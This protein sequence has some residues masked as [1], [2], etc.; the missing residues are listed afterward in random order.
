M[1]NFDG[2]DASP[3]KNNVFNRPLT[4]SGGFQRGSENNISNVPNFQPPKFPSE[5]LLLAETRHNNS[6]YEE[7][8]TDFGVLASFSDHP[9]APNFPAYEFSSASQDPIYNTSGFSSPEQPADPT[10]NPIIDSVIANIISPIHENY[11]SHEFRLFQKQTIQ[12]KQK[13][14]TS[15]LND[16]SMFHSSPPRSPI[17]SPPITPP[18]TPPQSPSKPST[19][20]RR[21]TP[22][23]LAPLFHISKQQTSSSN[24]SMPTASSSIPT[25]QS[26]SSPSIS[27]NFYIL[28]HSLHKDSHK[29]NWF[30]LL[31]EFF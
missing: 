14:F 6:S 11:K 9:N 29:W 30:L 15:E 10:E 18:I 3:F 17:I 12:E 16:N 19:H 20:G 7:M 4:S 21:I 25:A 1:R 22:K 24:L 23:S 27:Q 5:E 28:E 13:S 31:M 8:S 26:T 2:G